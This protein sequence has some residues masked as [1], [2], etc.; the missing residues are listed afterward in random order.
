M[1]Y[2]RY[3]SGEIA[4][5]HSGHMKNDIWVMQVSPQGDAVQV[6]IIFSDPEKFESAY[7]GTIAMMLNYMHNVKVVYKGQTDTFQF[8]I[9]D[10]PF[11]CSSKGGSTITVELHPFTWPE[12]YLQDLSS[13]NSA[14][15]NDLPDSPPLSPSDPPAS[16]PLFPSCLPDSWSPSYSPTSP[17]Y[18][19]TSP[20]Y[21]PSAS[22]YSPPPTSS[23]TSL[24]FRPKPSSTMPPIDLADLS[25]FGPI[26]KRRSQ[27]RH[28]YP[29]ILTRF[30]GVTLRRGH[31]ALR[32]RV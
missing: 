27:R 13:F 10:Q 5:L 3:G 15:P 23:S 6:D 26:P 7:E 18:E 2:V 32:M 20:T 22:S 11:F 21:S 12:H 9:L 14:S 31:I 4:A 28:G 17:T 19:A 1:L 25:N 30:G 16:P 29:Y 24:M 8:A